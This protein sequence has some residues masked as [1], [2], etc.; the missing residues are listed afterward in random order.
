M[1]GERINPTG[2]KTAYQLRE[3]KLDLVREMAMAQEENG[4]AILDIN[5]GM[6]GI[7]EKE[8]MKQVI[9]EVAATVDCPLC[10]DTSHIDVMEEALRVYPGR[11]LIN[12]VSLETEK[13]EHML[14]LAKSTGLC[15]SCFRFPMRD[16]QR[17]PKKS[18][19]LSIPYM[20][21]PW[22]W[23]WHTRILSWMDWLPQ[24]EPIQRPRKNVMIPSL[25]VRISGSFQRSVVCRIFRLVCRA[26][27]CQYG[28]SYHGNLPGLTM[29]IAN[30]SQELLM[31][32]AFASDMLL[33]RPDSDI[34]YIERMNKLAEEKAKYETV[35][36]K[37]KVLRVARHLWKKKQILL[38]QRF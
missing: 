9:Y 10:L 18:M 15:L 8:M 36:V 16:C 27:F 37:K 22:S 11:A 33:H 19:R 5:M 29:A 21:V 35:V 17:M 23:E 12:S 20:T 31:N 30:P 14:P 25:I 34:R 2:K 13:I 3:G 1:V 6:N 28:I 32:A 24:S 26:E 38:R 4:A 7:D